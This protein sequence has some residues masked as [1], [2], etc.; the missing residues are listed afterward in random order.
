MTLHPPRDQSL[1]DSRGDPVDPG[2][3]TSR[4]VYKSLYVP[5]HFDFTQ[6]HFEWWTLC[7]HSA[8]VCGTANAPSFAGNSTGRFFPTSSVILYGDR[9]AHAFALWAF[10]EPTG[11]WYASRGRTGTATCAEAPDRACVY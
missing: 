3:E 11:R 2:A 6:V 9:L 5:D 7:Y 10:F 1:Q 4:V 8:E